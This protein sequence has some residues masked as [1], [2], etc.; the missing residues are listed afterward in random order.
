VFAEL[1]FKNIR[2]LNFF[3]QAFKK[4]LEKSKKC[5]R[6]SPKPQWCGFITIHTQTGGM[7]LIIFAPV[8]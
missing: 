7:T 4:I 5:G 2:L 1:E 3:I 6:T 8:L